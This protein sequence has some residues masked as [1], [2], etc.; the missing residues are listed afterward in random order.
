MKLKLSLILIVFCTLTAQAQKVDDKAKIAAQ[1]KILKKQIIVDDLDSQAKNVPLAAARIFARL[2]I[3]EWLWKDGKDDTNR[4]ESLAVRALEELYEKKDEI[5]NSIF[6]SA[7]LFT[8]LELNAKDTAK[9]L[10]AQYKIEARE[11]LSNALSLLNKE[12]GDKILAAKIK[13]HLTKGNDLYQIS[14]LIGEL[15]DRKSQEV[16]AIL[17]HIIALEET[18]GNSF[19]ADALFNLTDYFRE[20]TV[21]ID[22]KTRFYRIILGK[23]R[24]ATQSPDGSGITSA[25]SLIYAVLPD[26]NQN[27]PE[28]SGEATALKSILSAKTSQ[29]TR[30]SRERDERIKGSEDKLAALISEAEKADSKNVKRDLYDDA[31]I[32]ATKQEKFQLAADLYGKALENIA[33]SEKVKPEILYGHHDQQLNEIVKAALD[34]D[35][36]ES[37]EYATKKIVVEFSKAEALRQTAIYFYENKDSASA[38][39]AY[40]KA[41]KLIVKQ[42]SA[43]IKFYM[44]FRLI[45]AART[46]DADRISEVTAITAKTVDSF[47][48][49]NPE[50]KPGTDK[51]NDYVETIMAINYNVN[52]VMRDLVKKNKSEA[53]DFAIR[54]NRKEVK[55]IADVVLAINQIET[56]KKQINA[57]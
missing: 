50:D 16:L 5:P 57:K 12:G 45:S 33:N 14:H 56:E 19:P 24:D 10:K 2:K 20:Q 35:D 9:K 22:L 38:L 3:A 51:F 53:N 52:Q 32:L 1:Q 31:G 13:Q 54:I 43:T 29:L 55:I 26:I 30:E 8:M 40:D 6:L 21:P 17:A 23:A 15:R 34:K 46:I 42:D 11:D 44:L 7:P 39:S 28:L 47:P 4:A 41:L 27:A 49:L 48:T 36:V 25:D 18:G 37:A